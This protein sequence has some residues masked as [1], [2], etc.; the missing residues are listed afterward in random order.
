MELPLRRQTVALGELHDPRAE[1]V[2]AANTRGLPSE[3]G[4]AG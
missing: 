3:H 4:R 2:R 1:F